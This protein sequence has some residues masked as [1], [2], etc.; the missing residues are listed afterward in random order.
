MR[1]ESLHSAE[2][3]AHK[4]ATERV[5]AARRAE[6]AAHAAVLALRE[7]REIAEAH[8][9]ARRQ[10]M[11]YEESESRRRQLAGPQPRIPRGEGNGDGPDNLQQFLELRL[12][13]PSEAA[14]ETD[15]DDFS[16]GIG[17]GSVLPGE[18]A[19]V[20]ASAGL[21]RMSVEDIRA[22]AGVEPV[23]PAW[24]YASQT[25]P[26]ARVLQTISQAYKG[27]LAGEIPCRTRGRKS[28]RA[29]LR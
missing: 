20:A 3:A 11:I 10:A 21:Q 28:Q 19:G 1:L 23:G 22:D 14:D 26:Q 27:E 5:E 7:E 25:P 29:G 12:A 2:L 17:T 9:S 24:L 18:I 4:A 8:S 15:Y 6:A 16:E 13:D